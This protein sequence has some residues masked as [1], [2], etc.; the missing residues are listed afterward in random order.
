MNQVHFDEETA[1]KLEVMYQAR[2][3]VRRR[4]VQRR[5][6]SGSGTAAGVTSSPPSTP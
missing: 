2:D 5:W 3:V 6:R 4:L 1:E